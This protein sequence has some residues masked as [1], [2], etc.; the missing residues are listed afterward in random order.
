MSPL[1]WLCSCAQAGWYLLG[2][3]LPDLGHLEGW[4]VAAAPHPSTPRLT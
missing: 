2:S 1:L 3:A 4:L